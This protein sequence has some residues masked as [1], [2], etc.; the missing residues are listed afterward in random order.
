LHVHAVYP[1]LVQRISAPFTSEEGCAQTT[2]GLGCGKRDVT[3]VK[4]GGTSTVLCSIRAFPMY[5]RLQVSDV[6]VDGLVEW[7]KLIIFVILIL[8]LVLVVVLPVIRVFAD[9]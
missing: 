1:Q 5:S 8:A 2:I 6:S 9:G 7:N 4:G 3:G